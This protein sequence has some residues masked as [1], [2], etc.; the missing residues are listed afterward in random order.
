MRSF[1]LLIVVWMACLL[2]LHCDQCL[3]IN[4]LKGEAAKDITAIEPTK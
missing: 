2:A 1:D 4:T 3:D